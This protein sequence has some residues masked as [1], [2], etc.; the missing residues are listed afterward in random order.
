MAAVSAALLTGCDRNGPE[1]TSPPEQYEMQTASRAVQNYDGKMDEIAMALAKSLSDAQ[2][3]RLIKTEASKRVDGDYDILFGSLGN[4]VL[5][6]RTF[7]QI[8]E[9]SLNTNPAARAMTVSALTQQLPLLNISVPVNI[10]KWDVEQYTPLVA[11][12]EGF[13]ENKQIKAFDKDGKVHWLDPKKAPGFPVVVVGKSERYGLS[14]SGLPE[15]KTGFLPL[16]K[17]GA[18]MRS[19][20]DEIGGEG[21]EEEDYAGNEPSDPA[22][23]GNYC[24]DLS[25]LNLTLTGW[26]SGNLNAIE[27]WIRGIPEIRMRA[28]AVRQ[29]GTKVDVYGDPVKGNL[30]PPNNRNMVNQ[31]WW[32]LS[33]YLFYWNVNDYGEEITFILHEEDGG[34]P[35]DITIP[36]SYKK[37]GLTASTSITFRVDD[38]DDY[39]GYFPRRLPFCSGSTIGNYTLKFKVDRN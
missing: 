27:N 26:Y 12:L 23:S 17:G 25:A 2:I 37:G 7:N 22:P 33:D 18:N 39:V 15:M 28:F 20:V 11:V 5:G 3:R 10:G 13:D 29:N 6:G 19:K 35:K 31:R 21:F 8:L 1:P 34:A 14:P 24:N 36:I 16:S 38:G 9:V 4:K 32:N 30:W